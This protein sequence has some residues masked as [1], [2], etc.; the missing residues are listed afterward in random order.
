MEA[1]K[2]IAKDPVYKRFL[3]ALLDEVEKNW[4]RQRS[5]LASEAGISSSFLTAI[6]K[7][8]TKA[9]YETRAALAKACGYEYEAF[10][11]FG[12]DLIDGQPPAK[13]DPI[14]EITTAIL[15]FLEENNIEPTREN[16]DRCLKILRDEQH[17]QNQPDNVSRIT[18]Q[19]CDLVSNP[20]F[21]NKEK[22]L[23]ANQ[24]LI[25]LEKLDLRTF[26]RRIADLETDVEELEEKAS[27]QEE[28][29][30]LKPQKNAG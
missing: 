14:N 4:D 8:E 10:L 15:E 22:G 1:K 3:A 20:G 25:K 30:N 5:A 27:K 7:K 19:H 23:K 18:S 28:E 11:Q 16:A 17:K 6:V 21:L 26:N 2:N 29:D 13:P 12:Q 24:L 9:S